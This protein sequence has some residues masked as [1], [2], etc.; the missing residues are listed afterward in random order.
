MSPRAEAYIATAVTAFSWA[1]VPVFMRML[2]LGLGPYVASFVVS[3]GASL[4]LCPYCLWRRPR[5]FFI[6]LRALLPVGFLALLNVGML[7]TWTMGNAGTNA[8]LSQI[9]PKIEQVFLIVLSYVIFH[10]ERGVI[11]HPLY[12]VGTTL[13]FAGLAGVLIREPSESLWPEVS[14]PVALL[15]LAAAAWA[16]YAVAAKHVS[17]SIDPLPLYTA[18]A[19]YSSA[20]FAGLAVLSDGARE[21]AR[22][23]AD[24]WGGQGVWLLSGVTG[25]S[26]AFAVANISLLYAQKHLGAAFVG[27]MT[28]VN[29]LITHVVAMAIWENEALRWTQWLGGAVLVFGGLLVLRAERRGHPGEVV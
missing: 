19:L 5:E 8:T 26:L 9:I 24:F 14:W 27:S 4:L 23:I 7:V 2:N 10:E 28:L 3:A 12:L 16:A 6:A 25:V 1:L 21:I 15:I 22:Q 29:P 17:L 13:S 11:R 18:V 20:G